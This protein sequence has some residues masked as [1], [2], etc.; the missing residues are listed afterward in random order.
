[1]P[2]LTIL[3]IFEEQRKVKYIP[4]HR[5]W[6][7]EYPNIFV[8]IYRSRMNIRIYSAWKNQQILGW[9]NIFVQIYLNVFEYPNVCATL[10]CNHYYQDD[11][12]IIDRAM[13]ITIIARIMVLLMKWWQLWPLNPGLYAYY[14]QVMY[15][16]ILTRIMV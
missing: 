16:T 6:T 8:S 12:L 4:Y 7:K 1:M 14:W 11:C 3:T 13:Y 2:L 9:M 15:V 5:Y 10:V